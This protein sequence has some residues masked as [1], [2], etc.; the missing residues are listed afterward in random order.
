MTYKEKTKEI[1]SQEAFANLEKYVGLIEE[2]NKV[3][4]LTGFKD[5]R[6]WEEGIFESI[7]LLEQGF[8]KAEGK[9]ILDIGAGA[10][11]PSVPYLI[12]NPNNSLT[13]YESS[14]KRA[15]F[16]ANVGKE[17]GLDINI[18]QERIENS[19]EEE[20]YDLVTARAVASLKILEEISHRVAK[21][22]AKFAFPKGPR[23]QQEIMD[24][25]LFSKKFG[26][27]PE[28][29]DAEIK[30]SKNNVLITYKK[31]MQTPKGY[32]RDWAMIAKNK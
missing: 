30:T 25:G 16:L 31:T 13:I 17:L 10:G 5:D 21:I 7:T 26:I 14:G 12:A 27:K 28:L 6:L 20:V 24:A 4:N 19:K 11:F 32:P 3:L 1:V 23:A 29:R 8:S 18:V 15:T 2:T 22:G 9:K